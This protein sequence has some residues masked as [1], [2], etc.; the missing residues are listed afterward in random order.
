[1]A[2]QQLTLRLPATEL[3]RA[4]S[5]LELAGAISISLRDD[6]DTEILEPEPGT[7]PL[8][9]ELVLRALFT[10]DLDLGALLE[11]LPGPGGL[12]P[13]L[14]T[15]TDEEVAA[16]ALQTIEPIEI[17]P[18]LAIVPAETT[19]VSPERALRLNMGLAFGTGRHPTTRLC[20][21]WLESAT[22]DGL[23]V[24]DY[25]CG[26][27]VLALAAL[28]LGA[29]EAVAIDNEPQALAATRR[30]AELNQLQAHI[31]IGLPGVPLAGTFGLVL[32]N[33]LARP[34][35]ELADTFAASQAAG[36]RIVL[37][38]LLESQLD[39]VENHYQRWY[40]TFDRRTLEGWGLLTAV[41]RNAV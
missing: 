4:E 14:A 15:L 2:W 7:T 41:R 13:E 34:L 22:L 18:R 40:E 26:T 24:L 10:A 5:L 9:P 33:I 3:P 38:G 39:E 21:Q 1:V 31:G 12:R 16:A 30:N 25:G 20:L 29:R 11:I 23:R 37:S 28:K 19:T 8:W 17:G 32:A 35:L 36:G 6:G 27:G